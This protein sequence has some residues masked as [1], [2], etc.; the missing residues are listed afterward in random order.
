MMVALYLL[1]GLGYIYFAGFGLTGLLLGNDR[2]RSLL[3][4]L[5]GFCLTV[6]VFSES[7]LLFHSANSAFS[8]TIVVVLIVNAAYLLKAHLGAG[9]KQQRAGLSTRERKI[10]WARLTVLGLAAA[11]VAFITWS[12]FVSGWNSYWG[13][14]NE[15]IFDALYGRDSYLKGDAG[16][17]VRFL[18]PFIRYQYS[19][20][21]F[22]SILF[23]SFGG[24]NVFYLQGQLMLF[25]QVA[26][27]YYLARHGF[28]LSHR[29][30]LLS[31][32]LG[33]CSSFYISTFFTGHEGSLIFAA[34]IPFLLGLGLSSLMR[35]RLGW[36]EIL[37]AGLWL[38]LIL[39]TYI[40]P[41]GFTVIPFVL[42]SLY[43][44]IGRNPIRRSRVKSWWHHLISMPSGSRERLFKFVGF[45]FAVVLI[46]AVTYVALDRIWFVLEPIRLRAATVFRA[47]GI[48]HY[49]EMFL[50]YWGILPSSIPFGVVA[51]PAKLDVPAIMISGYFGAAILIGALLYGA[52]A[53]LRRVSSSAVFILFFLFTWCCTFLVMKFMVVDPYYLYKFFYTN[54][55][56]GAI[57]LAIAAGE[58][59][60]RKDPGHFF[61]TR[62]KKTAISILGGCWLGLN[63][64]YIILYN[65]DVASRPYNNPKSSLTD[66]GPLRQYGEAGIYYNLSKFDLQNLLRYVFYNNGLPFPDAVSRFF[67][68]ELEVVGVDDIV[69]HRPGSRALVWENET[70]RLYKSGQHDKLG[71]DTY[72][73]GERYPGIYDNHPFRWVRDDVALEVIDPSQGSHAF[74]YCVEPGPGLSYQPFWL[75]TRVNGVVLDSVLVQGVQ[76]N[77][78]EI[79]KL[80][81]RVNEV[82]LFTKERGRN[83]L[84]WEERFLNYRVALIGIPDDRFLTE[85]LRLLNS[86]TDIVAHRAWNAL[87]ATSSSWRDSSDLLVIGNN[88][89]PVEFDDGLALRW[90]HNNAEL[91]VFNPSP[92]IETLSLTV[93]K[94][95]ALEN[96]NARLFV[97]LNG[98]PVDSLTLGER[99][100][101]QIALPGMRQQE[102]IVTLHVDPVGKAVGRDPRILNFRVFGAQLGRL[103]E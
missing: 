89:N 54:Y 6:A 52:M 35:G 30:A 87:T 12:F 59:F 25:L 61:S 56:V 34:V 62:M 20:L 5:N 16:E 67:A 19:S 46:C 38:L 36:G 88:W 32:L 22:W 53:I 73:Q 83:F 95:P 28:G 8:A 39:H 81:E 72:Y 55:Y 97:L 2:S 93:E 40:F 29:I 45:S 78:I 21:A 15:D 37:T 9:R 79:P 63:L 42:F 4:P 18:D 14:A 11:I 47:W 99:S 98:I 86:P 50:I 23:K 66:I 74:M 68:Y 76:V 17:V 82:Q 91:L 84:P 51:N 43:V 92:G 27:I 1:M 90:V 64:F 58:V 44:L 77:R 33:T 71:M 80:D 65:I 100:T 13:S 3:A 96:Q 7:F 31:A 26:G 48:S 57:L 75:Y 103:Q 70:I 41:L 94:G 10:L 85:A 102:N 69:Y 101:V 60:S 49:K 24:M